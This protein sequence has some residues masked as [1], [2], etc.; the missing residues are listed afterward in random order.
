MSPRL[1]AGLAALAVLVAGAGA[2]TT[3]SAAMSRPT[4]AAASGAGDPYFPLDGN[5]GYDVLHYDV[6]VT[7]VMSTGRLRGV[8]KVTARATQDLTSLHLDLLVPVRGVR[9]GGAPARWSRPHPHELRVVPARAVPAGERFRVRVSYSG[10]PAALSYLGERPWLGNGHEVLAMG[11]PHIAPWW[12]PA[13]DHPSDKAPFDVRVRV[14]RGQ[15]AVSNGRLVSRTPGERWTTY[16]W[17]SAPMATYL[18]FFAAGRFRIEHGRTR[19]GVPSLVA[20]SR[21]LDDAA[22]ASALRLLR[23][24]SA[25]QWWMERR[26]GPYPFGQTGGLTTS[27]RPGFALETQ[28]RPVYQAWMSDS[29][30]AHELA[31]QWLGNSVSLRRWSDIWLNE[32]LATYLEHWWDARRSATPM[33]ALDRWLCGGLHGYDDGWWALPIGA[34]GPTRLFA[35]QVYQRGA[36]TAHAL[37]TRIGHAAFRTLLRRWVADHRRGHGTTGDFVAL[38]GDVSGQD[39]GDFFRAWL[40]AAERPA[41]TAA[42][43]L[44]DC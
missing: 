39:L 32:G 22:Q 43:G 11:E 21:R 28:T 20:V 29:V 42:N 36:M 3:S 25:V 24:T 40:Y 15:Q 31:H 14:P 1:L 2:S 37:R 17:R 13:N 9:V 8:T 10:F 27:L 41:A 12:F 7:M 19:S 34:P 23:R 33:A 16:H 6:R 18:A 26:L 5:G 44:G 4:T 35:E 38:A 30:V